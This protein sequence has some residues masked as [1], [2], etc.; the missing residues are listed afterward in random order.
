MQCVN[1]IHKHFITRPIPLP[2]INK[3]LQ[4]R[5]IITQSTTTYTINITVTVFQQKQS[6]ILI[7]HN[8]T[9]LTGDM[10]LFQCFKLWLI[11]IK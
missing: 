6:K 1:H 4:V 9:L 11:L 7:Q 2:F 10:L 8:Q 3:I 5:K